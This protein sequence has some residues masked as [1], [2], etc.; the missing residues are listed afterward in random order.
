M[1][2]DTMSITNGHIY[3]IFFIHKILVYKII[4]LIILFWF[5][6]VKTDMSIR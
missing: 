2:F 6:T 3:I 1:S 4:I 5:F